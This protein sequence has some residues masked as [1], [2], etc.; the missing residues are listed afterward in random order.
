MRFLASKMWGGKH[1]QDLR[2]ELVDAKNHWYTSAKAV[3]RQIAADVPVKCLH[4]CTHN[5]FEFDRETDFRRETLVKMIGHA[6]QIA[7]SKDACLKGATMEALAAEYRDRVP[8]EQVG[9][10]K[11]ALDTRGRS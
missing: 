10:V 1:A 3:D 7:E 9:Q 6:K 11:L 5:I 2:V 8:L 4:I